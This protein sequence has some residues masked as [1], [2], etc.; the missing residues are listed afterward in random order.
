MIYTIRNEHEQNAQRNDRLSLISADERIETN[1]FVHTLNTHC[2][3]K[4][5]FDPRFALL[6]VTSSE[7]K[8]ESLSLFRDNPRML[9]REFRVNFNLARDS[10]RASQCTFLK[11]R[12][13]IS[14][15]FQS[16]DDRSNIGCCEY[17]LFLLLL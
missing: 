1:E 3:L 7:K 16:S 11:F 2:T 12:I 15:F 14:Y 4:Q 17:L 13:G 9:I 8:C 10:H 6:T 5:E